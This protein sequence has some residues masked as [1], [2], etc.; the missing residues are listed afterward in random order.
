MISI[1][2]QKDSGAG[3][4]K[5]MLYEEIIL[6]GNSYARQNKTSNYLFCCI[7]CDNRKCYTDSFYI[8]AAR[9]TRGAKPVK[10]KNLWKRKKYRS[11]IGNKLLL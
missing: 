3:K 2:M 8:S 9:S 1:I 4:K 5:G 6:S 10:R 7:T 11:V